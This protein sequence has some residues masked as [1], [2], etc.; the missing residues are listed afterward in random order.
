MPH[1]LVIDDDNEFRPMLRQTL[2]QMGHTVA[3]ARDGLQGLA[4]HD[5]RRADVIFTDLIMPE[6][7]GIETI[8]ELL[9]RTPGVRIVAMSGGG[10]SNATG[11][12]RVAEIIGAHH[13]LAK[14]FTQEEL[15]VALTRVL[16]AD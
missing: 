5:R 10:R 12:L 3:E 4:E 7:E 14:P 2:E 6:M 15:E 13:V 1:L 8:T 16:P 11:Y 9:R